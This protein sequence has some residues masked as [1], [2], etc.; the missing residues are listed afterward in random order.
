[1][2][3][4][5]S[6]CEVIVLRA[7]RPVLSAA[8]AVSAALLLSACTGSSYEEVDLDGLGSGPCADL[9]APA[10]DVSAGLRELADDETT[11]GQSA[12]RFATAQDDLAEAQP[13]ATVEPA[14]TE[15]ITRLG[16]F[17]V[18]VDSNGDDE[19]EAGRVRGALAALAEDC[20]TG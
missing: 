9:V 15:L 1:M 3:G 11:A 2:P 10:Q 19:A 8:L 17:R 12:E 16:F 13:H 6:V 7:R 18:A 5:G 20:R 14:L 4:T